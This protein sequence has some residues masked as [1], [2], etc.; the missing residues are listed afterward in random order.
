MLLN[1]IK[2]TLKKSFTTFKIR[3][4]ALKLTSV[5]LNIHSLQY[6]GENVI[7]KNSRINLYQRIAKKIGICLVLFESCI[8]FWGGLCLILVRIYFP[9]DYMKIVNLEYKEYTCRLVLTTSFIKYLITFCMMICWWKKRNQ[10]TLMTLLNELLVFCWKLNMRL[11]ID[12]NKLPPQSSLLFQLHICLIIWNLLNN[13]RVISSFDFPS[14]TIK[15]AINGV[16]YTCVYLLYQTVLLTLWQLHY[17]ANVK[18]TVRMEL[19]TIKYKTVLKFI[20]FLRN[21]KN[22][23]LRFAKA[24]V[25]LP[26]LVALKIF[27][28]ICWWKKRNQKTLRTLLNE[29]LVFCWKLNMRLDIDFNK[30][31]PQSSLLFQLH[32]CLIIWNLLNNMRVISSFD[33]PSQT[34]KEAING[35]YYTCVYLL[36]QTVLL[37]L[38]QLHYKANVKFE[39]RMVRET[40]KYKTVLK[41]IAFLRNLKNFQHRFAKAFVWL[42]R[43]VAL[44]TFLIVGQSSYLWRYQNQHQTLTDV[45]L[46]WLYT[47]LAESLLDM[48]LLVFMLSELC[49]LDRYT[50]RLLFEADKILHSKARAHSGSLKELEAYLSTPHFNSYTLQLHPFVQQISHF[51][52]WAILIPVACGFI[53]NCLNSFDMMFIR[54]LSQFKSNFNISHFNLTY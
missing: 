3:L 1:L 53:M 21:L 52:I 51:Q 6:N 25:W 14:Q 48:F 15:E 12:F 38:W 42:A 5:L 10:K 32:I 26:R 40:F 33:F 23:Q 2:R 46:I 44:K 16:Y 50:Q 22:F 41:F 27:L 34:I 54:D 31:P 4:Y 19:E 28:M 18:F 11:D 29:L 47:N 7:V 45:K 24:F 17:K 43:L 36:Y 9:K 37:T 30:L 35:V 13:M 20:A 8:L 39:M 49:R